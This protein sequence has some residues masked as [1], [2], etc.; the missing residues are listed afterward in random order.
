MLQVTQQL[1]ERHPKTLDSVIEFYMTFS[2][3]LPPP[4]GFSVLRMSMHPTIGAKEFTCFFAFFSAF[5]AN[6]VEKCFV[7]KS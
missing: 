2:R 3:E 7:I 6:I 5:V 1:L 4:A